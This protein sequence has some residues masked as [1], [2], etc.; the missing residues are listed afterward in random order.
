MTI[1]HRAC[2]KCGET[3]SLEDFSPHA[4]GKYGRQSRCKACH[5]AA[6][7]ARY[8]A[9]IEVEREKARVRSEEYRALHPEKVAASRAA[10]SSRNP[11]AD[12][13]SKDAYQERNR[14]AIN[15]TKAATYAR[16]PAKHRK[17]VL[18]N[19][20]RQKKIQRK[21]HLKRKFGLTLEQFD[22]MLV[23]QDGRC[24]ICGTNNPGTRT[25]HVDHDHATNQVRGLL[26]N[27]C[28]KGIGMLGEDPARLLAAERYLQK[29]RRKIAA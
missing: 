4:A 22:A 11:G 13:A 26:C 16:D 21:S 20:D 2:R 18:A 7:S 6:N 24:A 10:W 15:K 23:E 19:K 29:H 1:T 12:R 25:W 17:W 3:K 5:L 28:N 14:A 9:N 8:H 27:G